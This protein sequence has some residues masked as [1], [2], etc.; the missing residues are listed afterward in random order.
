MTISD[1]RPLCAIVG[2]CLCILNAFTH[3]LY[4]GGGLKR[5]VLTE[6]ICTFVCSVTYKIIELL[7][8]GLFNLSKYEV[9]LFRLYIAFL[10]ITASSAYNKNNDYDNF[11]DI[12]SVFHDGVYD[13]I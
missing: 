8:T 9:S 3:F 6:K 4:I 7:V 2:N 12:W 10:T 11:R 1:Q 5:D 13:I